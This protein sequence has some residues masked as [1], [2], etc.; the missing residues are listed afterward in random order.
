M[1]VVTELALY[2]LRDRMNCC[3]QNGLF[4][5]PHEI[6]FTAYSAISAVARLHS[7]TPSTWFHVALKQENVMIFKIQC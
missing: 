7:W 3:G 6:K 2:S 1:F 5:T 4:L